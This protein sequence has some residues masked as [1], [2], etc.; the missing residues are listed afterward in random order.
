[1]SFSGREFFATTPSFDFLGKQRFFL[2]A[3]ALLVILSVG[4]WVVR[5]DARYGVDFSGGYEIVVRMT[6][7]VTTEELRKVLDTPDFTDVSV[8]S[9]EASSHEFSFRFQSQKDSSDIR[10]LVTSRLSGG[11]AQRFVE[12]VKSDF[13]GPAVGAELQTK[14][15]LA[16]VL[17]LIGI[18]LYIAFRFEF[19][20]GFGAIIA[21]FHDV[22]VS[23]GIYLYTGHT[24]SMTTLAAALTILGY[25]V[26][27]TIVIFDRVRDELQVAKK[28]E[29]LSTLVNR[30]INGTLSRTLITQ[31]LTTLSIAA[32]MFLGSGAIAE[33]SVFLFAGMIT[34]TYS[35]IYIA[36][37]AMIWWHRMRG[38]SEEVA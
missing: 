6:E 29:T 26:N 1:M 37:P 7:G 12:I 33:L 31:G 24:I 16:V 28:G 25:S 2:I 13:V 35:T 30:S 4:Y 15:V 5:G 32:L 17:G 9:F 22:I 38:G 21:V 27:D 34:G 3:S 36:S 20:F 10:A 18:L 11:M 8:Q 14:G 19:A 23:T